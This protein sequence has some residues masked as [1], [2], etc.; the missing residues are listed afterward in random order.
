MCAQRTFEHSMMFKENEEAVFFDDVEEC[1]SICKSLLNN[2]NKIKE[3]TNKGHERV[4]RLG[5]SNQHA[6]P[7]I[8]KT[9]S[10]RIGRV[11]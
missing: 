8:L 3:I 1:I 9:I 7:L 5:L 10:K 4:K 11:L 2:E 6:I